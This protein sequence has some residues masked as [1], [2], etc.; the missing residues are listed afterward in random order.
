MRRPGRKCTS[1]S[2]GS[3]ISNRSRRG[4]RHRAH[5]VSPVKPETA[6]AS[7]DHNANGSQRTEP[8]TI[9]EVRQPVESDMDALVDNLLNVVGNRHPMLMAAAQQIFGAGGKKLRPMLVFLVARA[10]MQHMQQR[11]VLDRAPSG[12]HPAGPRSLV[13]SLSHRCFACRDLTEKHR[14]LAEITEMIHT[15]SLVHDDVL[16]ECDTRRGASSCPCVADERLHACTL[17]CCICNVLSRK[18][19]VVHIHCIYDCVG[20]M[21]ARVLM[22]TAMTLLCVCGAADCGKWVHVR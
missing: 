21:R 14:R 4:E 1:K 22:V 15:A 10:T 12:W 7:S 2:A 18:Q 5:V 13:S 3:R 9:D 8:V 19:R 11:C 20:A 6:S 16:D 17:G